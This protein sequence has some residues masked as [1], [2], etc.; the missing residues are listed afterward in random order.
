MKTSF[1]SGSV[2]HNR[3]RPTPH[4]FKYQMSWCLFDLDTIDEIFKHSKVWSMNK[5]NIV[6]IRNE[7][8]IDSKSP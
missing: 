1:C 4:R 6:S 5:F 2:I 7:D 8:Y 3:L